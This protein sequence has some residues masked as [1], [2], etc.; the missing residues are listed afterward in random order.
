MAKRR[1]VVIVGA[2]LFGSIAAHLARQAGHTVTVVDSGEAYAASKASGCVLAPS[3]L[4]SIPKEQ[5]TEA[6][7]VLGSEYALHDL[8]F[9]CS[10]RGHKV[11]K[12]FRAQR[13]NPADVLLKPDDNRKVLSVGDG[14]V[15]FVDRTKLRGTVLVAAGMGC[16]ELLPGM[17]KMRGLWGAS[18]WSL[19]EQIDAARLDVYAPYRQAVAFNIDRKRVWMGDGTALIQRTWD[20]TAPERIATTKD[21]AQDYMGLKLAKTV[22][23]SGARPYVIDHKAGYF[24]QVHPKTW[25]STGGAKNGT[26]LAAWQALR[27]LKEALR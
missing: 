4:A 19:G 11:P 14:E 20:A 26:I 1:N 2:G 23:V 21:R 10:V 12:Q 25:V 17:P 22:V 6:L 8:A 13:V 24:A 16:A 7:G 15:T 18:L 3:W 27:F 9:D 5:V